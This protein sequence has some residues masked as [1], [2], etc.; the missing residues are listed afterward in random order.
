MTAYRSRILGV[1]ACLPERVITNRDLTQ[2]MDTTHEWIVERTGIVERRWIEEGRTG[3]ELGVE[4]SR[5]ALEQ[6]GMTADQIDLV[7]YATL[8]PDNEFPGNGVYL[9]RD[10]GIRPTAVLD[11]RQQCS[12]FVYGLA[13]ADNFIRTG[14][15][16]N[17]LVVGSE[18]QSRGMV[19]STAQ[20]HISSLFGDGAG[21][22]VVGRSDDPDHMILSSHLYA[23]G[24]D[25]E[26]LC[27]SRPGWKKFPRISEAELNNGACD[28]VMEGRKVFKL[29]VTR[30]PEVILEALRANGLSLD[31]LDVVIPHQAN[32]RINETVL[33]TLGLPPEKMHN[34][35]E[36]YGNTTAATIPICMKDAIERGKIRPGSLV[37]L[38]A[39]GSGVTWGSILLRY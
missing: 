13:I 32:L 35:I 10:L 9:Q 22:A 7:V 17:A 25:A 18:V 1:G 27:L 4:A 30:L 11:I 12:G 29:A 6:A 23:D 36:K 28:P 21:A 20:R 26:I 39:F 24:K 37:A 15:A 16:T 3:T 5:E 38:A 34:N 19:L 2:W 33:K 8:S 14:M 31:D